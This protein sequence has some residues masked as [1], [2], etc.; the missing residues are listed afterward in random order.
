MATDATLAGGSRDCAD[1]RKA[2]VFAAGDAGTV[3]AVGV[4]CPGWKGGLT[5]DDGQYR[6]PCRLLE[7]EG[8]R[9]G[10]QCAGA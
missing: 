6:P 10:N 7:P 8:S 9:E 5:P 3:D 4:G 1:G 2:S